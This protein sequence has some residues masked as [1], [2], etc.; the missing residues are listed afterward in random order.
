[1]S[2]V[3][4]IAGLLV[5]PISVIITV[6]SYALLTYFVVQLYLVV[7]A[8]TPSPK[9]GEV[10]VFDPILG[11]IL[12][13]YV[14]AFLVLLI[15]GT[16]LFLP[17]FVSA[18]LSLPVALT[19]RRS[20]R[21]LVLRRFGMSDASRMLRETL[22]HKVCPDGHVY[23][24]ADRDIKTPWYVRFPIVFTQLV[25]LHFRQRR[26]GSKASIERFL[27]F[28]DVNWAR[29]VN[30][31][32]SR[33]KTFPLRCA[34]EHWQVLVSALSD[35]VDAIII[36]VS[37]PS[38]NLE[39]EIHQCATRGLLPK[40]IFLSLSQYASDAR[41]F[42]RSQ[43]LDETSVSQL[44]IYDT[45]DVERLPSFLPQPK[46]S[47]IVRSSAGRPRAH[48]TAA[49]LMLGP[50]VWIVAL[51]F[52]ISALQE[53]YSERSAAKEQLINPFTSLVEKAHN[54][55]HR[56][57]ALKNLSKI[58]LESTPV[59]PSIEWRKH[60][61]EAVLPLYR[62]L[63][64]AEPAHRGR[65]LFDLRQAGSAAASDIWRRV[66]LDVQQFDSN[67]LEL[68]LTG[69]LG[70]EAEENAP[71]L[72]MLLDR[73]SSSRLRQQT[74]GVLVVVGA[75]KAVPILLE[76]ADPL[77]NRA[78]PQDDII[79]AQNALKRILLAHEP[80]RPHR[81]IEKQTGLPLFISMSLGDPQH[82]KTR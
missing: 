76:K 72:L 52:G 46:D 24:L 18:L 16:Y 47:K 21:V 35:K 29:N 50:F 63:W 77:R 31:I 22:L 36:D 54:P 6:L 44:I 49:A 19:W 7:F 1:M 13:V 48:L 66:L 42:L 17:G 75:E 15:A 61:D 28:M 67:Q 4:R 8:P 33:W 81:L 32:V 68:T 23:T 2:A 20:I 45:D 39:W 40:T 26:I 11:V 53:I 5:P 62:E 80:V 79:V 69:I 65:I 14:K 34:D 51:V 58:I 10:Q 55:R 38:E 74:M 60:F 57:Q 27:R 73:T 71:D 78:W 12:S 56:G 70:A 25:F 43:G 82:G 59:R 64:D 3:R 30:W 37:R 9:P 41:E